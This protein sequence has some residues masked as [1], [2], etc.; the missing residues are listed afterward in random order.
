L[1]SPPP[2][3][4]GKGMEQP[5]NRI[6]LKGKAY[7][8]QCYDQTTQRL[9]LTDKNGGCWTYD[10]RTEKLSQFSGFR[11]NHKETLDVIEP[12]HCKRRMEKH[13]PP[14]KKIA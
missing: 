9:Y 13:P 6:I 5:T 8:V 11:A 12:H 14:K 2:N 4:A 7:T 3:P 1:R 10:Q